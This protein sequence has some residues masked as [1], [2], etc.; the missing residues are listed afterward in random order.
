MTLREAVKVLGPSPNFPFSSRRAASCTEEGGKVSLP[1]VPTSYSGCACDSNQKGTAEPGPRSSPPEE[2]RSARETLAYW[3]ALPA[4]LPAPCADQDGF[5]A[6]SRLR[7]YLFSASPGA[8]P[9]AP[10]ESPR[11]CRLRRTRL[12]RVPCRRPELWERNWAQETTNS[13]GNL[14]PV[15]EPV[16][17]LINARTKCPVAFNAPA[18]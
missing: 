7:E 4:R 1:M 2:E 14:G 13:L 18:V 9:H 6:G 12:S 15:A 10:P 11:V 17:S 16:S 3:L 5:P 8:F